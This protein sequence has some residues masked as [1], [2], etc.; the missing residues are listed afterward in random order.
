M[1]QPRVPAVCQNDF[2]SGDSVEKAIGLVR[3]SLMISGP[4]MKAYLP[5]FKIQED[6]VDGIRD[7]SILLEHLPF[8]ATVPQ[9]HR[10]PPEVLAAIFIYLSKR[11]RGQPGSNPLRFVKYLVSV[12]HVCKYWRQ[13]A[14]AA[15][16]LWTEINMTN[17]EAVEVFL[18]RSGAVPLNVNL[19][20]MNEDILQTVAP[21]AHRFRQFF[22]F[23]YGDSEYDPFTALMK[24]APLL[25][26]LGI[27]FPV[28]YQPFFI[29][30]DQTPRLRELTIITTGPWLSNRLGN[31]TSLHLTLHDTHVLFSE[32]IPFFEMLRRCPALE[33]MFVQW[34]TWGMTPEISA[35]PPTVPLHRLRKLLLRSS[36]IEHIRYLLH[37]LDLKKDGIA[38]HLSDVGF[39]VDEEYT[40][41][42]IQTAFPDDDPCQ[43]SL[44]SATKLE[45]I[46]HSR[47]RSI[48]LHAVGPGFSIRIERF[49]DD[50]FPP[51]QVGFQFHN[52]F[53]SVKELWVRG[54][55]RLDAEPNGFEHLPALEKLVLNGRGSCL[56]RDIRRA[57]SSDRSGIPP[58]PLLSSID[59]YGNASE[60]REIFLLV[61]ARYSTGH[62]LKKL[63]VPPSFI[64]LHADIGACVEEVKSLDI[65]ARALHMY[66][67]DLPE[68]CF[69]EGHRWWKPWKSRLR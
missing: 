61:H 18:E 1:T 41:S 28:F 43:P 36:R 57:L 60:M 58:C 27:S 30:D 45:L 26:R 23:A 42:R 59:C 52:I 54:S 39:R 65:P 20:S 8:P 17:L 50:Y 14:I 7:V 68:F 6:I 35:R 51:S 12:T 56:A 53:P 4:A 3:Y 49:T 31:L 25:E 34:N 9:I 5:S 33:E 47:P 2:T 67:M 64:P 19:R 15:P 16:D 24:P 46:F 10:L 69:A 11:E 62:Q 22:V 21:H 32:F 48:I 55:L 13:V 38:I 29:F 66:S 44:V 63:R 40:A 37:S